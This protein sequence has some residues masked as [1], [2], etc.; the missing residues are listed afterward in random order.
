MPHSRSFQHLLHWVPVSGN[1]WCL[2]PIFPSMFRSFPTYIYIYNY[3]SH[4]FQTTTFQ[5]NA[6]N[7]KKYPPFPA[8]LH[9]MSSNLILQPSQVPSENQLPVW[10]ISGGWLIFGVSR[11]VRQDS[12]GNSVASVTGSRGEA[13]PSST[14]RRLHT[15]SACGF[16][17]GGEVKHH[18]RWWFQGV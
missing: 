3:I 4:A 7:Q 5:V 8:K 6:T 1:F 12:L 9:E 14:V 10:W 18:S 15:H 2:P 17:L 11:Q 13:S 16:F